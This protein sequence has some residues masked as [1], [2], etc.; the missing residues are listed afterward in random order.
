MCSSDTRK[1]RRCLLYTDKS[2]R[3]TRCVKIISIRIKNQILIFMSPN[4]LTLN[5]TK[6]SIF[7]WLKYLGK[8]MTLCLMIEQYNAKTTAITEG[9]ITDWWSSLS[10]KPTN[11]LIVVYHWMIP[12][13]GNTKETV[14]YDMI[15]YDM[16]WC[17]IVWYGL[18][19]VR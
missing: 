19:N 2:Y 16:V 4:Y 8:I 5:L 13:R 3:L 10:C 14:W 15:S 7:F 17:W 6:F 12:I 11:L 18:K 9:S 1:K